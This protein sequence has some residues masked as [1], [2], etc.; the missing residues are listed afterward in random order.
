MCGI[1]LYSSKNESL[2][3]KLIPKLL[4]LS[5]KRGNDNIGITFIHKNIDTIKKSYGQNIIKDRKF[6]NLI[7]SKENEIIF[8][9]CRL[10]TDGARF[11]E[12]FNQPIN[13]G[14]LIGT[15]NGIIIDYVKDNYSES[16]ISNNDSYLFYSDLNDYFKN[17]KINEIDEFIKKKTGIINALFYSKSLNKIFLF[18]N[19]GSLFY[20]KNEHHLVI[21]SE[22][23]FLE[24]LK[25]EFKILENIEINQ[26]E[27]NIFY[28]FEFNNFE[29][30][31]KDKFVNKSFKDKTVIKKELKI[32]NQINKLKRCVKCILP[33]SYPMIKFDDEGVCNYCKI[34]KKQVFLGEEELIKKLGSTKNKI[35]YGLSGGVD[36]SY[37]LHFLI[38]E[39]GYKNI[40]TYTYDWGLTTDVSRRNISLMC[41]KLGV[42]NI[43]R[44]AD[45][46]YKRAC[47]KK[48]IKAWLKK[49]HLGM[50]PIFFIGD[51]PF[52]YYGSKIKKDINAHCTVHATGVQW[53]QMEF[54]VAYCN[55]NQKLKN[56]Q[57]MFDFNIKNKLH[58]F[59]WY[60]FQF[61]KNP[62]YINFSLLDNIIGFYSSF[63]HK[64][65]AIHLYNY[66]E[67]KPN[68]IERTLTDKYDFL[69]DKKYGKN[70]WRVG[71]GQTAFTNYI[72]YLIGGF[73][74]FDNYR[75]N[76]VRDGYLK[77]D[78]ALK[79]AEEDNE[80]RMETIDNF[81]R[82][83]NIDT[84]EILLKI[85]S[86]KKRY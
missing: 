79:L 71:D 64:D 67:Y 45:I 28:E 49:P 18:S 60:F 42:E 22:R 55:V 31:N 12:K 13:Y 74:E 4:K 2:K 59:I 11:N 72:Y 54:K 20:L 29:I 8:G 10:V 53:E 70:Q 1:F 50:V 81:C 76:Q 80:I 75:S 52:I 48:N 40:V 38:K 85:Q 36:S 62:S 5:K 15:H 46:K 57:R 16:P 51:K 73:S 84:E 61:V 43:L 83:V 63:V 78:E 9:Q 66:I 35:L 56:N 6:V 41:S 19:N 37:G 68:N 14:D 82:I 21:A 23:Y 3:G 7:N 24:Q 25:I 26:L 65:E 69:K 39:L 33:E 58:L 32:E 44:S 77:R 17:N 27:L 47:I 30:R 34:Y 86:L